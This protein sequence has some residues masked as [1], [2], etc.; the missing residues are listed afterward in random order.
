MD[1]SLIGFL[2]TQTIEFCLSN[3]IALI[4]EF[5]FTPSAGG[6]VSY[7]PNQIE[8]SRLIA[9]HV[10]KIPRGARPGDLPVHQPTKLE[11]V[12]NLKTARAIGVTIPQ[13]VLL[14]A[15]RLIE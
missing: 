5:K 4:G 2:R 6:L 9:D 14:R 13:S 10:D 8:L 12:I 7:G 11:L 15:D 3:K 1:D